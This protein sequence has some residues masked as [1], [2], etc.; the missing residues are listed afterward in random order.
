[1]VGARFSSVVS[2][3]RRVY[4]RDIDAAGLR[5]ISLFSGLS[6]EDLAR[7]ADLAHEIEVD[8]GARLVHEGEYACEVFVIE[9]GSAQVVHEGR[10]L[11]KLGIGDFFGELGVMSLGI[12]SA[13]VVAT[14]PVRAIVITDWGFRRIVRDT[15]AVAERIRTAVTERAREYRDR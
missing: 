4:R 10:V 12:R 8:E 14:S 3:L 6:D 11:A 5:S 7:V 1:M 15:P 2:Q 9:Q 13:D